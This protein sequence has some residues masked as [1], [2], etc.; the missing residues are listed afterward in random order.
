MHLSCV[1]LSYGCLS[2]AL[3]KKKKKE[4]AIVHLHSQNPPAPHQDGGARGLPD[5]FV[6]LLLGI[7][8]PV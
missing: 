1:G 3:K 8:E 7:A 2:C 4:G 5:S 6:I